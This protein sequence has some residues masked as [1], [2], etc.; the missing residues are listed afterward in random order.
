MKVV[1]LEAVFFTAW[2]LPSCLSAGTPF[3]KLSD[4]VLKLSALSCKS[5]TCYNLISC[6]WE[7]LMNHS[8]AGQRAGAI[9]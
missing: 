1:H 3:L 5:V 4:G 9:K 7:A 6:C 2:S 8:A